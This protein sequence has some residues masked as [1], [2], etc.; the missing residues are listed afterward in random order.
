MGGG[1]CEPPEPA[2]EGNGVKPTLNAGSSRLWSWSSS[3]SSG[4]VIITSADT[5]TTHNLLSKEAH[6]FVEEL[7][8]L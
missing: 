3:L 2:D 4:L 7:E 6:L 5:S 1:R 8:K